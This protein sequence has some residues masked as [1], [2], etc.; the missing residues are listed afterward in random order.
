[1]THSLPP[2]IHRRFERQAALTPHAIA[3]QGPEGSVTYADL[4]AAANRLAR[5]LQRRGARPGA[6]VAL[7]LERGA[8]LV[9]AMLA[10]L[11][12]GAAYVPVDPA[13]PAA[14]IA[15][16]LADADPAV[17]V[18]RQDCA[19][20]LGPRTAALCLD[21]APWAAEDDANLPRDVDGGSLAYVIYTS[22]STGEPK[23][24]LVEHRQLACHVEAFGALAGL[25]PRDRVLQFAAP[26]FDV[27]AEEVWPTLLHGAT[28]VLRDPGPA[29]ALAAF[30]SQVEARRITVL[31]LPASFWHPW[32]DHV[33]AAG[34][35]V[36]LPALRQ[37]VVGSE[38]VQPGSVRAWEARF[39][40]RIAIANAYGPTEAT[41]TA[42]AEQLPML[43]PGAARVPIGRPLAGSVVRVLDAGWEPVAPGEPGELYIGG[44][45]LARGYLNRP[46]LTAERFVQVNGER[47]Y[48]TGD[49]VAQ[50]PDGSLDFL[51]R[52]DGQLKV[53]GQRVEPGDVEACLVRHAGVAAA[54]VVADAA[55]GHLLAYV[56]PADGANAP[57]PAELQALARAA[58]PPYMVPAA[59]VGLET[60]PLMANG[61]LDRNALPAPDAAAFPAQ[62]YAAPQDEAERELAALWCALLKLPRVGR[63]EDFFALGGDAPTALGLVELLRERGQ[64]IDMRTF[65]ERPTVAALAALP[66]LPALPATPSATAPVA[67]GQ[68]FFR[69]MLDGADDLPAPFGLDGTGMPELARRH[70]DPAL[71]LRLRAAARQRGLMPA[72]LFHLAWACVLAR[73]TGRRDVLFATALPAWHT[74]TGIGECL[75]PLRIA[76][77]G[78]GTEDA[79]HRTHLAIAT[80]VDHRH[81]PH[82]AAAGTT[83]LLHYRHAGAEAPPRRDHPLALTVDDL[84][85]GFRL[86]AQCAA[87][88]GPARICDFMLCALAALADALEQ[89]PGT[90]VTALDVL[91]PAERAQLLGWSATAPVPG[92]GCLHRL[93]EA[94]A[95]RSPDAIALS[96]DGAAVTYGTLNDAANRLAHY[97]QSVGIGPDVPVG[98]CMPAGTA[99]V[100]AALG[101]LK[102]GGACLPLDAAAGPGRIGAVLADAGASMLLTVRTVQAPAG[103]ATVL[104]LDG[105]GPWQ[106]MPR[107]NP[108]SAVS[109]SDLAWIVYGD[110]TTGVA[111]EHRNVTRLFDAAG[112]WIDGGAADAWTVCASP[113]TDLFLWELWGALLAGARAVVVPAGKRTPDAL[114]RLVRDER[115]TLLTLPAQAFADAAWPTL[116]PCLRHVVVRGESPGVA[117]RLDSLAAHAE[118]PRLLA[119]RGSAETGVHATCFAPARGGAGRDAA[120]GMI[121]HPLPD[122]SAY[123]LDAWGQPAPLGVP[124]ELYIGGPGLARGYL[125]R[126][127]M[128]AA[129][130]VRHPLAPDGR[131]FRTG[132][133]ARWTAGGVL[134]DRGLLQAG[135]PR[136]AARNAAQD[137]APGKAHGSPQAMAQ[138]EAQSGARDAGDDDAGGGVTAPDGGR[139]G[140]GLVAA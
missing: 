43:P 80:L 14:R 34:G 125:H 9:M 2:C 54:L 109:P 59:Y 101:V 70:V 63:H 46:D 89:A 95:A 1:M 44:T 129:R 50:L 13:Y 102:A 88:A 110:G 97:L 120:A 64:G 56:T 98:L 103:I 94:V 4:N 104:H 30:T 49:L 83:A 27:L 135:L 100:V 58:L 124:G 47:L 128:T 31:N 113:A 69:A 23:G 25:S 106:A 112:A 42:T 90:P 73:G 36:R 5:H 131:M 107:A 76:L 28:L 33:L 10:V 67:S 15:F 55:G 84:G 96:D 139:P 26:A 78:T 77:E 51:G 121:G 22:G 92:R 12:T 87:T 35:D 138:G 18:T 3:L 40:M 126:P 74:A 85:D 93:V 130:F 41:V 115:V 119:T 114:A 66:A 108:A 118:G 123:V 48:R 134:D 60:L 79:L 81:V 91:P 133:T 32:C 75:L 105:P 62:D 65:C 99:L 127:E 57:D 45:R 71:A 20:M 16:M 68:A 116:A 136:R 7:C 61:K 111:L 17:T 24:V 72:S 37:L 8:P 29:D 137:G 117:A 140:A 21:G 52:I 86:T 11:K 122:M 19:G 39:G 82:G 6:L 53:H 38:V 132:R